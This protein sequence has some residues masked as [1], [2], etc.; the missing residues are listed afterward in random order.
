MVDKMKSNQH[1]ALN[2]LFTYIQNECDGDYGL[3]H[4]D[5]CKIIYCLHFVRDQEVPR[6]E[7][8]EL[9]FILYKLSECFDEE[10]CIG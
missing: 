4:R 2:K 10:R 9:C 3:I 1:K 6:N 7:V 5:L 8:Q